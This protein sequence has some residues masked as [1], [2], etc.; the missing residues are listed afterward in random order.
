MRRVHSTCMD[1]CVHRIMC[2]LASYTY[3]LRTHNPALQNPQRVAGM[4]GKAPQVEP[5]GVVRFL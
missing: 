5:G 4:A 3:G 1:V 2:T